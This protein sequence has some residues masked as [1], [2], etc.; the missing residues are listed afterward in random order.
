M[1]MKCSQI[2]FLNLCWPFLSMAFSYS[3]ES[4]VD[5]MVFMFVY[6]Y[7]FAYLCTRLCDSPQYYYVS[8]YD[9]YLYFVNK[10]GSK[11]RSTLSK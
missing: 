5:I 11:R 2:N 9:V 7:A 3:P 1:A 10:E 4:G 8:M 6:Y